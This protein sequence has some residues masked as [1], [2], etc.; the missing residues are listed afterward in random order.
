MPEEM[1]ARRAHKDFEAISNILGKEKFL[2]GEKP[3]TADASVFG[4]LHCILN[5]G[6]ETPLAEIVRDHKN[7]VEY[8][9]RNLT[10]YWD[11][12]AT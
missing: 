5:C 3:C 1:I 8:V 11:N 12:K 9:D 4:F 10:I 6:I 7:L 2:M